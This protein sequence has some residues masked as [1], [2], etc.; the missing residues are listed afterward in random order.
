MNDFLPHGL[1]LVV[2]RLVAVSALAVVT[3]L[4]HAEI[5]IG[6]VTPL[7]GPQ[8]VT[9]KAISAGVKLYIDAVNASGGVRGQRVKL[10]V[11]DDAQNPKAT[12]R[13]VNALINEDD[14][15]AMIGTVGTSNLEALAANGV[16]GRSRVP[17]IGAIS[18]AASVAT[19][20]RMYVVK[21]RYR[22]EVTRLFADLQRLSISRVGI[23]YQDDGLG[24]DVLAGST[25]AAASHG[26]SL[27]KAASYARN[28][29]DTTQAVGQMIS[30][31]PDAIFLGATTAAAIDFVKRYRQAGG[32][33]LIYGMSI[34]DPDILLKNLGP[35][36]A[37]GYAFTIV[38][39]IPSDR[40]LAVVREYSRLRDASHDPDLS[41][42]SLEGFIAA[43]AVVWALKH[44][45]RIEPDSVVAAL[46]KPGGF[47]AGG[48]V[49]D[50]SEKGLTGSHFVDFAMFG[51]GGRVVR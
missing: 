43:K 50:F 27:V 15:V 31:R 10:V 8:A 32:T 2:A 51:E 6:Q 44:A 40:R 36:L 49:L 17:L 12:V 9:G 11:R 16:L 29:T 18:G 48:Y 25:D 28:T 19:S 4:T 47:D 24:R 38:M 34:I 5:V 26:L 3:Q 13:E 7:S 37:R 35:S 1:A 41:T 39:P 45:E 42:R 33:A 20:E 30:A 22:D 23:V 21:A 46:T 14:P